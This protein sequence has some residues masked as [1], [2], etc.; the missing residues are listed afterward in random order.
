MPRVFLVA[1]LCLPCLGVASCRV[2][3][4]AT[5]APIVLQEPSSD[6]HDAILRAMVHR[7]WRPIADEPGKITAQVLV[8]GRH[9]ATVDVLYTAEK[10]EFA[11]VSSENLNYENVDGEE[12]IHKNYNSWV[13]MLRDDIEQQLILSQKEGA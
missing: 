5:P 7:G 4:L 12:T 2:A 13:K 6:V 8:R 1:L 11:Y 3:P 10:V 9:K